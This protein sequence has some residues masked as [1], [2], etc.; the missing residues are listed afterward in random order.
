MVQYR[1]EIGGQD[2]KFREESIHQPDEQGKVYIKSRR[3]K[4]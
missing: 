2:R 3:G 1:Q 4:Q